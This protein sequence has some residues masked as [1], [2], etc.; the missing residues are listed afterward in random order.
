MKPQGKAGEAKERSAAP[1][2]AARSWG[3]SSSANRATDIGQTTASMTEFATFSDIA[4]EHPT[5][6]DVMAASTC[7]PD[8]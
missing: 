3:K 2:A 7:Q 1:T 6:S 5:A 4:G 8:G